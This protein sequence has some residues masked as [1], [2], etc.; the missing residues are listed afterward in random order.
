MKLDAE[1]FVR[2]ILVEGV[3][4]PGQRAI[5]AAVAELAGPG[6][7]HEVAVL[8][9]RAA[10]FGA[11]AAASEPLEAGAPVEWVADP[12]ARAALAGARAAARALRA[13][14]EGA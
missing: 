10:G 14:L 13:A 2:Q 6:L 3:G 7:E 1:R 5:G 4:E 12:S 11:I 8:Y 9:A